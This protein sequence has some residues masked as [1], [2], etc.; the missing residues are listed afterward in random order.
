V[1]DE[2]GSFWATD[3]EIS[4]PVPSKNAILVDMGALGFTEFGLDHNLNSGDLEEFVPT[5]APA[6]STGG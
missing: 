5:F 4:L 3:T 2:P 6:R 1:N